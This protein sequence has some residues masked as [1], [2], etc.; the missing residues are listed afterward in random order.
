MTPKEFIELY[1]SGDAAASLHGYTLGDGAK[2]KFSL[3]G[4]GIPANGYLVF[5]KDQ[6]KLTLKNTNGEVLLYG[7]NGQVLDSASFA[8]VAPKGKVFHAWITAR[9]RFHILFLNIPRRAR[10]TRR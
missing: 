2:K 10:R 7:Q 3:S 1:N 5:M 9:H 4:Y 6:D 8:G